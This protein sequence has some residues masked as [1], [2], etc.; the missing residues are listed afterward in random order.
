MSKNEALNRKAKP[1]CAD[2]KIRPLARL[3]H[4][5]WEEESP[6][7]KVIPLKIAWRYPLISIKTTE[8]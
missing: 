7:M 4:P 2:Q 6:R 5:N 8:T 1:R 3:L